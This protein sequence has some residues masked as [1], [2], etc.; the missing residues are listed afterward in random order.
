[1]IISRQFS[2]GKSSEAFLTSMRHIH[3]VQHSTTIL[4][5]N[6][7]YTRHHARHKVQHAR[8]VQ[9]PEWLQLLPRV[10][11]RSSSVYTCSNIPQIRSYSR[12]PSH[13]GQFPSKASLRPLRREAIRHSVHSTTAREPAIMAL[14]HPPLRRTLSLQCPRSLLLQ[15]E[16]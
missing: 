16:S 13:R 5:I 6:I 14:P 10:S 9:V 15:H 1:M 8:E 7:G 12:C 2:N 11:T 3:K 4:I